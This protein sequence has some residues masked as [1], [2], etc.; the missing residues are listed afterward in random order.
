V[1]IL[2]LFAKS[3]FKPMQEHMRVVL[4]CAREIVP[5]FEALCRGDRRALESSERRID[6]LEGSADHLKNDLRA[7]LPKRLLLPVDRRDLL[8]I[9]DLQDSIADT[10]QDIAALLLL[11]SMPVPETMERSL[12][13]FV[14]CVEHACV[15]AG[16]VIDTL[17]ELVEIG[18]RGREA[19]RAE[20]MINELCS[21]EGRSDRLG[22]DLAR[23]LFRLEETLSPVTVMFWYGLIGQIGDLA[24]LA[25]KIGNRVRL[26][27]AH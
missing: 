16:S 23:E 1:S 10:A 4:E 14:R 6:E 11:R 22:L 12:L 3:P 21:I 7:H 5:L 19:D 27:I 25:E 2:D 26:L 24:D 9:L 8:E 15:Q 20:A 13:E 18:F 17:D